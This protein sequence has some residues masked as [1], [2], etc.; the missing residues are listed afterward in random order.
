MS[1]Y[2]R[3]RYFTEL[4]AYD[5]TLLVSTVGRFWVRYMSKTWKDSKFDT[6]NNPKVV[7]E[8]LEGDHYTMFRPRLV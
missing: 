6:H 2:A 8:I 7:R 4:L 3:V 5:D 1:R